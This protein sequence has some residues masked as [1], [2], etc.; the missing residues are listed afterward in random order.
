MDKTF[1]I[2][3]HGY[4]S[5]SDGKINIPQNISLHFA[6]RDKDKFYLDKLDDLLKGDAWHRWYLRGNDI[7]NYTFEEL[8]DIEFQRVKGIHEIVITQSRTIHWG[9][10]CDF[11]IF[12]PFKLEDIFSCL[13]EKYPNDSIYLYVI[14]CRE[15]IQ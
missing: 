5:S 15:H 4:Y 11:E 10:A 8:K 14:S 6:V 1:V 12:Y 9:M 2:I 13:T 7:N 3:A